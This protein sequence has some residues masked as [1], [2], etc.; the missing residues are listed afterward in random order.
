MFGKVEVDPPWCRPRER[1]DYIKNA[2]VHNLCAVR[3]RRKGHFTPT[4]AC[5]TVVKLRS[6][7]IMPKPWGQE[8]KRVSEWGETQNRL[9]VCR[10]CDAPHELLEGMHS[11]VT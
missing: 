10:P 3:P 6:K 4:S 2:P 11:H 9:S 1:G 7:T 8:N 5:Q